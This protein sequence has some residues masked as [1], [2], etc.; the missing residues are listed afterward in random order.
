MNDPRE[1]LPP[2]SPFSGMK[3]W[4]AYCAR[5]LGASMIGTL[6]VVLSL[7]FLFTAVVVVKLSFLVVKLA[8]NIV[9]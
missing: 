9:P 8:W 1:N 3:P 6:I 7:G 4:E 5:A 2:K